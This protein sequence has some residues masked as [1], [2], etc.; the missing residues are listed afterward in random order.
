MLKVVERNRNDFV[1][2]MKKLISIKSLTCGEKEMA[3]YL[4]RELEAMGAEEVF[5]D[6]VGNVIAVIRGESGGP[7]VVLNAHMDAVPEGSVE[8]WAPYDPYTPA[9]VDGRLIGR[10]ISDLKGGLAAQ[11]YA[12]KA[13]HDNVVKK[14]RKLSG[15][16]IFL[17]CV[18]EES[19]GGFGTEYFIDYTMKEKNLKCDVVFLCEPSSGDLA[20]GQRGK[21][22]LVVKTY[23]K[24]AHSS[25]PSEGVNA[26]ELM[27]PILH[28]IFTHTGIELKTDPLLGECIITVTKCVVLPGGQFSVVPDYC[29][30]SVDRRYTVDQTIDDL[31][32]EFE[33]IFKRL[34]TVYPEFK[35]TVEPRVY[36]ETSYTGYAGKVRKYHP[37]WITDKN[38]EFVVKSFKALEKV[39]QTPKA[40]YWRFGTDGS[41][42][43]AMRNLTTIGYSGATEAE[44]HQPKESVDIE[45]MVKTYEGYLAILAEIYGIDLSAFE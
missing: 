24:C 16:L 45:D 28:D 37:P 41:T 29:E 17:A 5:V 36:D 25:V 43:S 30:I 10:G 6:T 11:F 7:S 20:L 39:G 12:F 23:G 8:N 19:G 31:L 13:I 9:V 44:A 4:F 35:A 18:Q 32:G 21:V 15:D 2:M 42:T 26:L 22:E 40:K 38:N 3:E 14:G 33:A 1:E 34:K 27:V